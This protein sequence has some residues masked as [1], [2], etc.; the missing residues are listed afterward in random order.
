MLPVGRQVPAGGGTRIDGLAAVGDAEGVAGGTDRG[1][2]VGEASRLGW[3]DA[4]A[5][6][7]VAGLE[8]PVRNTTAKSVD[9]TTVEAERERMACGIRRPLCEAW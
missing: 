3:T 6:G 8:Q 9:A 7:S 5:E 4:D 1:D 2:D